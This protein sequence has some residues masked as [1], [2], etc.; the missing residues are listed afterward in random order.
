MDER[1]GLTIGEFHRAPEIALCRAGRCNLPFCKT[2]RGGTR[3]GTMS[4]LGI[5]FRMHLQLSVPGRRRVVASGSRCE[6]RATERTARGSFEASTTP[7]EVVNRAPSGHRVHRCLL[8]VRRRP[9]DPIP[10]GT[11]RGT[12][13][14]SSVRRAQALGRGAT[15]GRTTATPLDVTGGRG[16]SYRRWRS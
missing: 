4:M 12:R 8:F 2:N 6:S 3:G 9:A 15:R 11:K 13:P 10:R 5:S 14:V 1:P 7:A 16:E